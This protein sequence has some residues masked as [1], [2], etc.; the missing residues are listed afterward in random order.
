MRA[1]AIYFRGQTTT[2]LRAL[3][4]AAFDFLHATRHGR[5][6]D[7]GTCGAI[8]AFLELG[9]CMNRLLDG[10]LKHG[11]SA[12]RQQMKSYLEALKAQGQEELVRLY[13]ECLQSLEHNRPAPGD[14]FFNFAGVLIYRQD[15]VR[16]SLGATSVLACLSP[17]LK[18]GITATQDENL[19]NILFRIVMLCQIIDDLIDARKDL[20]AGLPS[21]VTLFPDMKTALAKASNISQLYAAARYQI[22]SRE[23]VLLKLLLVITATI[24]RMVI[25]GVSLKTGFQHSSLG[26]KGASASHNDLPEFDVETGLI[27]KIGPLLVKITHPRAGTQTTME[28]S[29]IRRS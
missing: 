29:D 20:A 27:D 10:K 19:V 13:L 22:Q 4:I 2:P 25:L 8:A 21:F 12:E 9:A 17:D 16:L 26:R 1:I 15:V 5:R 18:S 6:L 23:M 7:M 11:E 28:A 14:G 3:C 24:T